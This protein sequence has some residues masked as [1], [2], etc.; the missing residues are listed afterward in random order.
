MN[1]QIFLSCLLLFAVP[2][3][4]REKSDV[5]VMRNGD[6]LTCEIKSLASPTKRAVRSERRLLVVCGP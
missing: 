4:A 5:L 6:R 2:V 1:P 3:S